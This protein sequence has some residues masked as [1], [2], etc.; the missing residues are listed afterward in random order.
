MG[1]KRGPLPGRFVPA[2]VRKW[3]RRPG[4]YVEV[5]DYQE[6]VAP[7]PSPVD[8]APRQG[9]LALVVGEY[10]DDYVQK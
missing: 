8:A 3:P 7:L 1:R 2:H 9:E 5:S 4:E 10:D 6:R